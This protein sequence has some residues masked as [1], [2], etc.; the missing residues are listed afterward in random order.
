MSAFKRLSQVVHLP[1]NRRA[2]ED[3]G[4][5]PPPP[6][7]A[8]PRRSIAQVF[9]RNKGGYASN[10]ETDTETDSDI[11]NP[12]ADGL[13]KNAAKR[14][15]HKMKKLEAKSRLSIEQTEA[16]EDRSH[17]R[18]EEARKSETDAMRERYG[19]LPLMQSQTWPHQK[20]IHIDSINEDM[21]GQEVMFRARVHHLRN[22]S[23]KLMF[24][25]FRQQISTVQGVLAE[26]PGVISP[27]MIHWAEHLRVGS[28]VLVTGVVQK[29]GFPIKSVT[30]HTVEVKV[31]SLKVIVKREDPSSYSNY[32]VSSK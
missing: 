19:D 14:Q 27:V 6:G 9:S 7:N 3:G 2:S 4:P 15:A 30:N 12:S 22:M 13:S 5:S 29:P 10:T 20:R 26:E 25:L 8:S 32:F 21:V 23:Q 28:V 1:G 17:A 16:A 11:D 18:L 31:K 24:I